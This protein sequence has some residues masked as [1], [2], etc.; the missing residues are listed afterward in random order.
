M[1]RII[2]LCISLLLLTACFHSK[3]AKQIK[4]SKES[5][6]EIEAAIKNIAKE[7]YGMD[8]NVNMKKLKFAFPEGKNMLM[9][10]DKRLEVPVETVGSPKY[11]F[12]IYMSIYNSELDKYQFDEDELEL[13]DFS[14]MGRVLITDV[15]EELYENELK[16]LVEFD[17]GVELEVRIDTR[18][19]RY[20]EDEKEEDALLKKFADDY[21]AGK[22]EDPKEYASLIKK[23][24]ELPDEESKLYD[25]QIK[26]GIPCTPEIKVSIKYEEDEKQTLEEKLTAFVEFIE[27][28]ETLPNG[29]YDIHIREEEPENTY[30]RKLDHELVLRCGS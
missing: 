16:K 11:Q 4:N 27:N 13:R 30:D 20:F 18:F 9:K 7:K 1:K 2:V 12:K 8:V 26:A 15:Y 21:N 19:N 23:H 25:E 22:F 17:E 14:R 3:E 6:T 24:A 5:K 10:T 28:E 29:R